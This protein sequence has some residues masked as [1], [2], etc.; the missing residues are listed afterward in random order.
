MSSKSLVYTEERLGN[1]YD[2]L[3][4]ISTHMSEMVGIAA[5]ILS[6]RE[7]ECAQFIRYCKIAQASLHDDVRGH[8]RSYSRQSLNRLKEDECMFKMSDWLNELEKELFL[9]HERNCD[10]QILVFE[11]IIYKRI[12]EIEEIEFEKRPSRFENFVKE[13]FYKSV[14]DWKNFFD[15]S[16]YGIL[17]KQKTST[18]SCVCF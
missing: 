3:C 1:I 17:N 9:L 15:R 5:T 4:N 6:I 13:T 11:I 14:L 2:L 12:K 7:P 16:K 18:S 8:V 10:E